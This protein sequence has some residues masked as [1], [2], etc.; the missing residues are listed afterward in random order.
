MVDACKKEVL[1]ANHLSLD[2]EENQKIYVIDN[3]HVG[4]VA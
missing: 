3:D 4:I 1:V 2:M